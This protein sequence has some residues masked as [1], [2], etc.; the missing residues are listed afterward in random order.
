MNTIQVISPSPNKLIFLTHARPAGVPSRKTTQREPIV[1][2][3]RAHRRG[4][5]QLDSL[6]QILIILVLMDSAEA[7]DTE[8]EASTEGGT[9]FVPFWSTIST[10]LCF[11]NSRGVLTLWLNFWQLGLKYA[12]CGTSQVLCTTTDGLVSH[13]VVISTTLRPKRQ[14]FTT[15]FSVISIVQFCWYRCKRYSISILKLQPVPR[16]APIQMQLGFTNE[17]IRLSSK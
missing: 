11:V 8:S 1:T 10:T 17:T 6:H 7:S 4:W 14:K 5:Y 2:K 16:V 13:H 12:K 3:V 9:Q 15:I